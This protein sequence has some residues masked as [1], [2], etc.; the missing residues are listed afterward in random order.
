MM[1]MMIQKRE[2]KSKKEKQ[3]CSHSPGELRSLPADGADWFVSETLRKSESVER[4]VSLS[5]LFQRVCVCCVLVVEV[6][7]VVVV[8][9][10]L[11]QEHSQ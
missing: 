4:G 8:V 5:L 6:V 9:C 10:S 11:A 7:V 1:M 3:N 2:R